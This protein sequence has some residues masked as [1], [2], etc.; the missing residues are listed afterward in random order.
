MSA[1][2]ILSCPDPLEDFPA[3]FCRGHVFEREV[4]YAFGTA[5]KAIAR[6]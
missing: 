2:L 4:R 3:C 6:Y 1:R 5:L